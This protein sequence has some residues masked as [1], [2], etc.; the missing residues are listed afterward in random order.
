MT[1]PRDVRGRGYWGDPPGRS[2]PLRLP[3]LR[4][5]RSRRP[6]VQ[7]PVSAR[8]CVRTLHPGETGVGWGG[9]VLCGVVP[10][11]SPLK[12]PGVPLRPPTRPSVTPLPG[13]AHAPDG[14]TDQDPGPYPFTPPVD[15]PFP[16]SIWSVPLTTLGFSGRSGV[17][18]GLGRCQS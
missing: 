3:S 9:R 10:H 2:Y 11:L 5:P 16:S 18:N 6:G 14:C 15:S 8:P 4:G 17:V 12:G 13:S 1:D 7:T